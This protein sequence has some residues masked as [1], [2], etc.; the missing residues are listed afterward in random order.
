MEHVRRFFAVGF[1]MVLLLA[2]VPAPAVAADVTLTV[3]VETEAGESISGGNVT[4]TWDG[5]SDTADLSASG[6]ALL[7]VPDGAAVEITL[8]HG[9]YIRNSPVLVEDASEEDVTMTVHEISEATVSVADASGAVEDALVTLAQDG[10]TVVS[11]R[12]TDGTIETGEIEAGDY[13]LTVEKAGYYTVE[14]TIT[15]PAGAS[16]HEVTINE[17]SV[18]LAV[19]VTD[20]YFDPPQPVE[21]ITV[22]V[23]GQ[24]SLSTQSNGQ[25]QLSVPVNTELTVTFSGPAHETV[26]RSVE[27]GEEQISLE[28]ELN[29]DDT[30]NVT[31]HTA[32]VVVG[33]PAFISVTDEYD[34]PVP[35]ATV[36]LNG[37]AVTETDTDGWARIPIETVGTH[38][39]TVEDET[40][41]S[42]ETEIRGVNA[43]EESPTVTTSDATETTEAAATTTPTESTDAPIPGFGLL[44]GMIGMALAMVLVLGRRSR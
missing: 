20:P 9:D 13:T 21:G 44:V 6:K 33:Q 39:I 29:R 4:A 17:G 26:E 25:Q 16:D 43:A 5:G 30:L 35:N 37:D 11:E 42:N 27:T 38:V 40:T 32:D 12:T 18:T 10:T 24:G 19:N 31:V 28:V 1:V 34:D 36:W 8:S 15:V 14:R 23:P 7:D 22:T 3:G 2:L 41:T